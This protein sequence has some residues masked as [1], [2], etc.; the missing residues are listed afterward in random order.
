MEDAG[1]GQVAVVPNLASAAD[2]CVRL[3]NSTD[4]GAC[5]AF[6]IPGSFCIRNRD[7][8]RPFG[9]RLPI[10]Y[11]Y[12][13]GTWYIPVQCTVPAKTIAQ[14]V[15]TANAESALISLAS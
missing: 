5:D 13:Y 3:L 14:T 1:S 8:E 12:M 6:R 2:D 10:S 11:T 15:R 9:P 4:L 7:A